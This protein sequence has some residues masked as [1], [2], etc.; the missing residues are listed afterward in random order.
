MRV[1]E[2][3]KARR[4]ELGMTAEALAKKLG[5]HSTTI[6]RYE[7]GYI[8]KVAASKLIPIAEALYT[9][10]GYLMGWEDKENEPEPPESMSLRRWISLAPGYKDWP[11]DFQKSMET[12]VESIW[13]TYDDLSKIR[14]EDD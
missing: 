4:I 10:P 14:K 11:E 3:I 9:T 1:G 5:C 8:E 2:R 13:K 12:A 7:S 6:Y